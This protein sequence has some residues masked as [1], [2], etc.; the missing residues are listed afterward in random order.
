MKVRFGAGYGAFHRRADAPYI[1]QWA[2]R[3]WS[4]RARASSGQE[5]LDQI[6]TGRKM[7]FEFSIGDGAFQLSADTRREDLADQ[8]YLFADKLAMPRWDAAPV[9]RAKAG[10]AAAI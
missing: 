5:Q 1:A 4:V 2:P 7:G 9:L 10:G 3:R 6:S 8:L